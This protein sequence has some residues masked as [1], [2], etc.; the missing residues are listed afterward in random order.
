MYTYIYKY[1]CVYKYIYIRMMFRNK[2]LSYQKKN[3]DACRDA[4]ER[5]KHNP[6]PAVAAT[7]CVLCSHAQT[8]K[9][10]KAVLLLRVVCVQRRARQASPLSSG[11]SI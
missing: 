6:T 7:L 11:G 4:N 9:G 10:N 5:P 3:V 1:M 8:L 2:M